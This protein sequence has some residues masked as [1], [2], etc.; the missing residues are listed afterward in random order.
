MKQVKQRVLLLEH[1]PNPEAAIAAAA[2]LCYSGLELDEIV[3]KCYEQDNTKFLTMLQDVDHLSPYEHASFVFAVEGVSRALLAQITR[4]RL[5]S[6]SVRSQRYVSEQEFGYIVPPS[7][8][9]LGQ[10]AIDK[11]AKQMKQM[12]A[13]YKEWQETLG[14]KGEKSNEDARFVLPNATETKFVI[15]MNARELL[16]FFKLRTCERAQWEI[17]ELAWSM[18]ALVLKVAPNLFAKA[19]PG[20]CN[21]GC[22]EG[23]KACGIAGQIIKRQRD[24]VEQAKKEFEA[25]K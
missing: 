21:T 9:A 8:E 7:I 11:Y 2:K 12:D 25:G 10:K 15:T 18:L 22:K 6:F 16:H 5:A 24:L 23:K 4:H 3:G 1:T 19:G 20:C 14:G 17:R 13:W